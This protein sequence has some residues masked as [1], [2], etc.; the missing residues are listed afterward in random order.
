MSDDLFDYDRNKADPTI[1]L[2]Y[3]RERRLKNA[4]ESV[5][6]LH[7]GE[8][9][10]KPGLVRALFSTP[11]SGFLALAILL[12]LPFIGYTKLQAKKSMA[13]T[14]DFSMSLNASAISETQVSAFVTIE[15]KTDK[16]YSEP[17][18]VTF[19]LLTADD[20]I[21]GE[22]TVQTVYVS[23]LLT[24]PTVITAKSDAIKKIKAQ[25]TVNETIFGLQQNLKPFSK[26]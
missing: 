8:Y 16:E 14:E 12:M 22:S 25:V 19:Y 3:N 6:K 2:R 24:I 20:I 26:K 21:I 13:A 5:Q 10:K 17:V 7:R 15:P 1:E 9:T 18:S 11:A 23:S 4:P